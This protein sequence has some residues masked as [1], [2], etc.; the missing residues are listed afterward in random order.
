MLAAWSTALLPLGPAPLSVFGWLG[1]GGESPM[2]DQWAAKNQNQLLTSSCPYPPLRAG[3]DPA[4]LLLR[5]L[6]IDAPTSS[7]ECPPSLSQKQ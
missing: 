6:F 2:I 7:A 4:R 5:G 3:S 1:C